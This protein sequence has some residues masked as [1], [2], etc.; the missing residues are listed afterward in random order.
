VAE[1]NLVLGS[2]S[3]IGVSVLADRSD[4]AAYCARQHAGFQVDTSWP[5][6]PNTWVVGIVSAVTVDS[7]DHVWI[8]HRPRTVRIARIKMAQL[9]EDPSSDRARPHCLKGWSSWQKETT[10][11]EKKRGA[12]M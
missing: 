1:P 5:K 6:L 4:L 9:T 11:W 10:S 7:R 12:E 8:L 2:P 3:L